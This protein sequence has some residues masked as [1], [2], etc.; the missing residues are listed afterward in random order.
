MSKDSRE[1]A[2]SNEVTTLRMA[3]AELQMG[4]LQMLI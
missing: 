1:A 4:N 2:E 3:C